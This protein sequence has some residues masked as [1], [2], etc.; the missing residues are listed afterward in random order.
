MV[1]MEISMEKIPK[2]IH[3][4]WFGSSGKP[5]TIKKCMKSWSSLTDYKI[6][7]WNDNKFDFNENEY[8]R[9]AFRQKKWAHL[10]DYYRLKVLYE[11]GGIYLDTD[12]MINHRF[13]PLLSNEMFLGF[14]F[15]CS[16][17]SAVIGAI[18]KHPVIREL[19]ELYDGIMIKEDFTNGFYVKE[20]TDK[21]LF[22]NNDLFTIYL[23]KKFSEF[24]LVNRYQNL[25]SLAVYPKEFFE[26][27]PVI[28]KSYCI[29]F[30]IG[31][32]GSNN[33]TG[34]KVKKRMKEMLYNMPGINIYSILLHIS[35]RRRLSSLPFY[36]DYLEHK[37]LTSEPG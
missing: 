25:V 30:N 27:P 19:I 10:S 21:K 24:R 2:I 28:G 4:F 17:G 37:K 14:I 32:W 23:L 33:S 7:E 8:T 6:I 12:V 29:H 15:D 18:P 1:R 11:Y 36:S 5:E 22:N 26:I 20:L 34:R 16:I 9:E 13:D 31:S 3:C 35:H